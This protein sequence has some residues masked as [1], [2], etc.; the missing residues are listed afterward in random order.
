MPA[1][2]RQGEARTAIDTFRNDYRVAFLHYLPRADESALA[3]AYELGRTAVAAGVSVLELSQVHHEVL[4]AVLREVRSPDETQ[5]IALAA[6]EL[7]LEVLATSEMAHRRFN[8]T[9]GV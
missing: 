3:E 9:F 2:G 7:L 5:H 4:A 8:E 6:S 1:A